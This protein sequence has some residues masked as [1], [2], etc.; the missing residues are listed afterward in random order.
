MAG[1][2]SCLKHSHALNIWWNLNILRDALV[3]S[4]AVAQNLRAISREC[5]YSV[6][7][8]KIERIY[9]H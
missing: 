6:K 1:Y 5:W 4:K 8:W 3:G 9:R 7:N 2:R